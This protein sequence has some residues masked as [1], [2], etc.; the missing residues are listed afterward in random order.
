M[1][2]LS[3]RPRV[4][5]FQGEARPFDGMRKINTHAAGVDS[6][7]HAIV[8]CVP[9][10]DAPQL[11]RAFGPSTAALDALADWFVD[12]GIP[13]SGPGIHGGVLD[14]AVC[15]PRSPWYPVLSEQRPGDHTRPRPQKRRARLSVDANLAQLRLVESFLSSRRGPCV[16]AYPLTSSGPTHCA[17]CPPRPPQAKS[18]V[19]DDHPVVASAQ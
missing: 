13:D 2:P 1:S 7:A 14:A 16:P 15:N 6:G 18:P 9:D 19:A 4:R 10:G 11:V 3:Q 12:R 17:S 8:A 5:S